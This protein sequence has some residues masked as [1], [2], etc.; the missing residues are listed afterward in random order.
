MRTFLFSVLTILC[1]AALYAV[2]PVVRI[3]SPASGFTI[4]R[5]VDVKGSV[6]GTAGDYGWMVVNGIRQRIAIRNGAFSVPLVLSRGDNSIQ[7]GV[8][9]ENRIIWD[10]VSL[11]ADVPKRDIRIVLNWDTNGSDMD[12]WV[13]DPSGE[14]VYYAH[15][16]S[17]IGGELDVD[18]TTGYGPETFTLEHARPG[19]YVVEV[20]NYSPGSA[21]I[22]EIT[23]SMLLFPDTD[24]EVRRQ[25]R[26]YT[27]K[28]TE[29]VPVTRF[30][31]NEALYF[32][33]SGR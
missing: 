22:T 19:E 26:A 8:P 15:R 17:A 2:A 28:R 33:E 23:V 7:V 5:I 14:R 30:S 13:W 4:K 6:T 18:I 9:Y 25:Y 1:A 21:A 3:E 12:L 16:T 27:Y 29:V 31:I 11:Y 20:H 24:K 10:D 32:V